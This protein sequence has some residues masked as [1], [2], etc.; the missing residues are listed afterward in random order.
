MVNIG[1][2]QLFVSV[3]QVGPRLSMSIASL[4]FGG[5]MMLGGL[6]VEYHRS[7]VR[8]LYTSIVEHAGRPW[9]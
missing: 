4:C 5:G 9:A 6:G 2:I 8:V 1:R 7:A 3:V